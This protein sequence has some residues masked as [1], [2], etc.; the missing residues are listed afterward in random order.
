MNRRYAR[1]EVYETKRGDRW[2]VIGHS[3][4]GRVIVKR[5]GHRYEG[6]LQWSP[7]VLKRMKKVHAAE[8]QAVTRAVA[9]VAEEEKPGIFGRFFGSPVAP[10]PD[11]RRR[12]RI[13][14][15]VAEKVR[16]RKRH[17]HITLSRTAKGK[18]CAG[19]L[20]RRDLQRTFYTVR[21]ARRAQYLMA[22]ALRRPGVIVK[23]G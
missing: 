7:E 12:Q 23:V 16:G 18:C 1:D 8:E 14:V 10:D 4:K 2:K 5:A 15:I 19:C 22:R 20:R 21:N 6:E 17:L 11:G 13:Y 9:P 3:P